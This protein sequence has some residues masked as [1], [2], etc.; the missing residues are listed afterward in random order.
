M[1]ELQRASEACARIWVASGNLYRQAG[2]C[3]AE[4]GPDEMLTQRA[5]RYCEDSQKLQIICLH[6]VGELR[7]L[8]GKERQTP[9]SHAANRAVAIHAELCEEAAGSLEAKFRS[10]GAWIANRRRFRVVAS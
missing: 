6:S 5:M 10:M 7:L 9:A 1:D 8:V 3:M 2:R 4:L